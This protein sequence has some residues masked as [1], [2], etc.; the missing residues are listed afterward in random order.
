[1]IRFNVQADGHA[2]AERAGCAFNPGVDQVIARVDDGG[3]RGG[4]I[5]QNYTGVSIN[6]HLAGFDEQWISRDL[7]WVCF[8]Y[9]FVQL[10]CKKLFGQVPSFNTEAYEL[11]KKFGFKEIARIEGV[12]PNGDLIV[13]CMNREDCRWLAMKPRTLRN[14]QVEHTNGR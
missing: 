9:P 3:L 14:S 5:Y 12:F 4:A 7:I 11:D 13:M 6:A 8:H 1:M 10:D 2:I